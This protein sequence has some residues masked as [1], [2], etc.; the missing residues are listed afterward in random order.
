MQQKSLD[1]SE[2]GMLVQDAITFS[3][4][5]A[6]WSIHHVRR[7][8]NSSAHALAKNATMCEGDIWM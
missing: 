1:W 4:L 8:F 5:F 2:G 6:S 3:N 7:C